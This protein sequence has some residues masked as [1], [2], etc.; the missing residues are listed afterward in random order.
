MGS[1]NIGKE[2][3][4][5]WIQENFKKGET[6]LDVGACNGKWYDLIGDYLIMDAV[7]IWMPNIQRY[8]LS[9]KYRMVICSD[10]LQFNYIYYDLIIFGDVL[11]HM[12]ASE[13][14]R[15]IEYAR[16]RCRDS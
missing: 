6:C 16:P 1:L 7:E 13:A 10:I 2:E 4:V 8:E 11:E 9:K 5:R 3:A 15:V 12:S 14:R